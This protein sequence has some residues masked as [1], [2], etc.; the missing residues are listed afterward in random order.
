MMLQLY[1]GGALF[2]WA[3]LMLFLVWNTLIQP[4]EDV[5]DWFR[6][7]ELGRTCFAYV[8]AGLLWPAFYAIVVLEGVKGK[9]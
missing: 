9:H 8:V 7:G 6:P 2:T 1:F 4:D 3:F 5:V